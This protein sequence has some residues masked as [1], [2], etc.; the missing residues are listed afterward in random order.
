MVNYS[1]WKTIEVSDDEDDTHPNIDTPYLF[2]LRHQNLVDRVDEYEEKKG[3]NNQKQMY[4][5]QQEIRNCNGDEKKWAQLQTKLKEIESKKSELNA[6]CDELR[7]KEKKTPWNFYTISK[8]GFSK[9][10]INTSPKSTYDDL[11]EEEK[12]SRRR[13]FVKDNKKLLKLFGMM[14]KYD[15]SKKFLLDHS[16]LIV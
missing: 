2:R 14:R 7:L 5:I 8:P 15:D 13:D 1:D 9:T 6:K 12:E 4:N 11:N 16:Q 3:T 10:I